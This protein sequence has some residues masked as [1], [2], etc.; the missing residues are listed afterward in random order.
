M[1]INRLGPLALVYPD[2][3]PL[4]N[5]E[6]EVRDGAGAPATLYSS[7]SGGLT[8]ENPTATDGFGMLGFYAEEGVYEL[9]VTESGFTLTVVVYPPTGAAAE[10]GEVKTQAAPAA[11]WN[12][13]HGLGRLPTVSLYLNTGEEVEADVVASATDV[14]VTWPSPMA[15][16]LVLT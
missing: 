5:K 3:A 16:K 4:A 2:G 10:I 14:Y 13:S 9:E 11:T 8:L 6:I 12:F 15:G 1:S 7:I